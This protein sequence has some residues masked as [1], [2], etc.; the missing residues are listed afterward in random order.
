MEALFDEDMLGDDLEAWLDESAM[1][2]RTFRQCAVIAGLI[3]RRYPGQKKTGRQVTISTD[4]I[5]D[6]LRKHQPD[7]LLLR[8]A[9]QD[10]AT[11]LLDVRRLGMMLERIQGRIIHRSPDRVS[12]PSAPLP[13]ERGRQRGHGGC[14]CE[15][16][17]C[18]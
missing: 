3:E 18:N 17:G 5:Y 9:R 11:G 14:L 12:P 7:H 15:V 13:L 1:M 6:V 16:G 10:A 8:A 2:K 4:L